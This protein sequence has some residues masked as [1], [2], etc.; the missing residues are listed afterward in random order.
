MKKIYQTPESL[1]IQASFKEELLGLSSPGT[2]I[3]DGG[4][5]DDEDDPSAKDRKEEDFLPA[6]ENW[7]NLW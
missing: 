3:G 5:G 7:G 1:H 2:G 4:E 6:E